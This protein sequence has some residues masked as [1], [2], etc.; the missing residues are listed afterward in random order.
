MMLK[1]NMKLTLIGTRADVIVSM[2]TFFGHF[3]NSQSHSQSKLTL[4]DQSGIALVYKN[5][6]AGM[7]MAYK[8]YLKT[9]LY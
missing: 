2:D 9:H 5:L 8:Y 3:F 1:P 4:T 6:K 7:A